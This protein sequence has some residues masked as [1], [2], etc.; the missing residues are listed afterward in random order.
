MME[1]IN[2][3]HEAS[4]KH[5]GEAVKGVGGLEHD[6]SSGYAEATR[7]EAFKGGGHV[8]KKKKLG[9][10]YDGAAGVG[11]SCAALHPRRFYSLCK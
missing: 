10:A 2:G 11:S 4:V 1:I 9:V 5:K 7:A 8:G 3:D 6:M